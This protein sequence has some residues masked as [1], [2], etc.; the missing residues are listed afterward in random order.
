MNSRFAISRL[1]RRMVTLKTMWR[2]GWTIA[3]G[4]LQAD[5]INYHH[6]WQ[7][8]PSFRDVHIILMGTS[9]LSIYL[10]C[11]CSFNKPQIDFTFANCSVYWRWIFFKSTQ[12][13]PAGIITLKCAA[14]N[15][16][17]L[18]LISNWNQCF[19]KLSLT[20]ILLKTI[21]HNII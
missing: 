12:I 21:Q 1:H 11:Q 14:A 3:S 6:S 4:K 19:V 9:F 17:K 20:C 10:N 16:K 7:L 8:T 2:R 18:G 13:H 5:D 15:Q